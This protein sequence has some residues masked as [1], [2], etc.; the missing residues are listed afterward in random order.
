MRKRVGKNE[1][2][3]ALYVIIANKC[4]HV[5]PINFLRNTPVIAARLEFAPARNIT[6]E[7]LV[8]QYS[9]LLKVSARSLSRILFRVS[10]FLLFHFQTTR[11]FA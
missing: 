1:G 7:I 5:N 4:R 9:F 8:A 11:N 3:L 2:N 6:E 10:T